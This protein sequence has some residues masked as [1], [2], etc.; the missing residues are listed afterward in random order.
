MLLHLKNYK[1]K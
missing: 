1:L